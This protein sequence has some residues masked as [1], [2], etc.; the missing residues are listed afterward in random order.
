M[1]GVDDPESDVPDWSEDEVELDELPV[2]ELPVDEVVVA[3]E[4]E[5]LVVV[6][7]P[8]VLWFALL[9]VFDLGVAE[10]GVIDGVK[11]SC[12]RLIMPRAKVERSTASRPS[13]TW[14][15][16]TCINV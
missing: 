16:E 8:I 6:P 1:A 11:S 13:P 2:D 15:S 4:L 14:R 3:G 7:D 5:P 12:M 10:G 9:D